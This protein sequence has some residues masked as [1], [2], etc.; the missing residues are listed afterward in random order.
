M[1]FSKKEINMEIKKNKKINKK[2]LLLRAKKRKRLSPAA[3]I[4]VEASFVLPIFIFFFVN[5]LGAFDIL[6]LQCDMVAAMHQ[7]GS[8][9]MESAAIT[10]ISGDQDGDG[11]GKALEGA[12][13]A[14]YAGHKV[15]SYFN[16]N[17]LEHSCVVGGNGGISFAESA[18]S[19]GGDIVDLVGTCK[20]H[21]IF[22]ISGFTDF[23]VENRF[24]GHAFTGYDL[25]GAGREEAKDT[26]ELVYITES[27]TVYHRS[28]DCSHLKIRIRQVSK[29]EVKN[30]R[31]ADRAKYYPCEYCG[32]GKGSKVYIT[33][34]GN[35]YHSNINC[36]GLKR[37]IRTVPISEVGGRGPCSECG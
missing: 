3:S 19:S 7:T 20:V 10:A 5:I 18:F 2:D 25:A 34:Y 31:N 15:K 22:G 24:Y 28:L 26:E 12:G 35:R 14:V 13:M 32:A 6:K 27:G 11:I 8:Q 17:Q 4:T 30:M 9:I 16:R 29:S 1:A 33:N 37:T 21:P 23:G 36:S